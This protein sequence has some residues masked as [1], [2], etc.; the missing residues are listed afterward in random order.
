MKILV[1]FTGGTIGSA[2]S[3]GMIAPDSNAKYLLLNNYLKGGER[4]DVQFESLVPYTIL[5]ENLAAENLN[6]LIGCVKNNLNGAYDGI[7]I[8]HGTD[9]L[10][11]TAAALGYAFADAEIPI[12]IVSS[13]Y[14]LSLEKANGNKNF[15]AAVQFIRQKIC[16]GVFISYANDGENA[17]FHRPRFALFHMETRD[18]VKSIGDNY[19]AEYSDGKILPNENFREGKII[20]VENLRFKERSG[21]LVIDACPASSYEY[22]LT[23]YRAVIFR[24]YHS[25]TLCTADVALKNFCRKAE[26]LGVPAFVI[27]VPA[28]NRYESTSLY[29]DLGIEVLAES[30]FADAYIKLWIALSLGFDVKEFMTA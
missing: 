3:D 2:V 16:R 6:A 10:Q 8:A 17:K 7:I 27:N 23:K 26:S 14:V 19:Y 4:G 22:D 15:E 1:I 9:T 12:M 11:F 25:G 21:I 29:A 18:E 28:K 24:P 13:N 30:T 5:S 20:P